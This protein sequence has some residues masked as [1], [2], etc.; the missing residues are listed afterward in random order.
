MLAYKKSN[1]G[2][3][4]LCCFCGEKINLKDT[5]SHLNKCKTNFEYELKENYRMPSLYEDLFL[6]IRDEKFKLSNGTESKEKFIQEFNQRAEIIYK[7]FERKKMIFENEPFYHEKL[8]KIPKEKPI[9]G[10]VIDD[11]ENLVM[12]SL[13]IFLMYSNLKTQKN[14]YSPLKEICCFI[15]GR[16]V[17][18]WGIEPHLRNC[19]KN[20]ILDKDSKIILQKPNFNVIREVFK[21][22]EKPEGDEYYIEFLIKEFNKESE[23]IFNKVFST[24]KNSKA[25][26]R[27]RNASSN[28]LTPSSKRIVVKRLDKNSSTNLNLATLV[29]NN[30]STLRCFICGNFFPTDDFQLHYLRCKV[31]AP[32]SYL[33]DK[34]H[35]AEMSEFM[36]K[37]AIGVI[38][39]DD[40]KKFNLF[41]EK[42]YWEIVCKP[43]PI[44]GKKLNPIKFEKHYK[45]CQEKMQE[46]MNPSKI[47]VKKI[48]RIRYQLDEEL[49]K[50]P[51]E[52]RRMRK[53]SMDDI[54]N[55]DIK[56]VR[57]NIKYYFI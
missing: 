9:S 35:I 12:D 32:Q 52:K 18:F 38:N 33:V 51:A 44:C 55:Y 19:S 8:N 7:D 26:V 53:K 48:Q 39:E 50:E 41:S 15:C 56:Q 1:L 28:L 54:R 47:T 20:F 21:E 23:R 16:I 17:S 4:I 46:E 42:F 30:L 11:I 14:E 5:E 43:C 31:E 6:R 22:K 27:D 2:S 36:N 49:L 37:L 45:S 10:E 40:V 25:P 24:G 13:D 3:R 34:N 29:P 57:N